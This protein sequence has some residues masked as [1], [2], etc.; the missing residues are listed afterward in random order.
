M[1]TLTIKN[2]RVLDPVLNK[3]ETAT[4]T[5]PVEG[6]DVVI[7]GEGLYAFPAFVDVHVHLRDPGC[8]RRFLPAREGAARS[9][10]H[11]ECPDKRS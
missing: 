11:R 9:R 4:I 2:V 7:D 10:L 8:Y 5:C 3:N 1:A 6:D